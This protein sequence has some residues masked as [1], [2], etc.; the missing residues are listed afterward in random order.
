MCLTIKK[1]FSSLRKMIKKEQKIAIKDIIVFKVLEKR[2]WKNQYGE[3]TKYISPYRSYVYHL[4]Y[5][6]YQTGPNKFSIWW[7]S[8][9]GYYDINQ[10]LH[11]WVSLKKAEEEKYDC[12]IIK[13]VIP[14]GSTYFL[15]ANND[16]VTDNLILLEEV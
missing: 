16:V 10:G 6:Y 14:K 15:G 4:G 9:S 7:N 12:T 3:D 2:R 1:R 8:F 11:A 5:H 13:C